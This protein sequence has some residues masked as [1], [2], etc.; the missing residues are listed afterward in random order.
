VKEFTVVVC[1]GPV[2]QTMSVRRRLVP[3]TMSN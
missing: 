1:P 3:L 2:A